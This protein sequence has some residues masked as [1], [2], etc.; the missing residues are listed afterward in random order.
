MAAKKELSF[1][2]VLKFHGKLTELQF[3]KGHPNFEKS[4]FSIFAPFSGSILIT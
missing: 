3:E 1:K 2:M 4:L